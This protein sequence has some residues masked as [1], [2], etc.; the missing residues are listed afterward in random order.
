MGRWGGGVAGDD[1]VLTP[2]NYGVRPGGL[3][4]KVSGFRTLGLHCNGLYDFGLGLPWSC[5]LGLR[6]SGI[7]KPC[8]P[9]SEVVLN[10]G[11]TKSRC[12]GLALTTRT[13]II[14]IIIIITNH[15]R[16]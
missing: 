9:V 12:R 16:T 3:G 6:V 5:G 13:I 7:P 4:L 1:M 2:P 14:I 8:L 15:P 11:S 10:G